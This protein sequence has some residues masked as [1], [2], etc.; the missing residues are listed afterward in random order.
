[1]LTKLNGGDQEVRNKRRELVRCV[2]MEG[3]GF[4]RK[5][6][7]DSEMQVEEPVTQS[8]PLQSAPEPVDAL[9]NEPMAI[10]GASIPAYGRRFRVRTTS[11]S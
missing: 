5:D 9:P 2:E 1:M 4:R 6:T 10:D 7:E 8:S 11:S 3:M